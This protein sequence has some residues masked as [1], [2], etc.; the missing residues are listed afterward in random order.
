MNV[1]IGNE[2]TKFHVGEYMFRIFRT[3]LTSRFILNLCAPTLLQ[4]ITDNACNLWIRVN[5]PRIDNW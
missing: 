1:Q 2:A 5:I 4:N 3:V